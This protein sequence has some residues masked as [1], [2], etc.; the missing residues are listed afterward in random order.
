LP[1]KL[2]I[3]KDICLG[4]A[5]LHGYKIIHRDLKPANILLDEHWNAKICDF[6]LSEIKKNTI[7]KNEQRV[8]RGSYYW[9]SPEA[10]M[11]RP[12]DEKTDIYAIGIIIWQLMTVNN[13]PLPQYN[14]SSDLTEGVT[15]GVRPIFEK[16]TNSKINKKFDG[17]MLGYRKRKKTFSPR[18]HE[19]F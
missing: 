2:K 12:V 11:A 10:L 18:V 4:T 13:I 1:I 17:K 14:S 5:W 19:N 6:G 7:G 8:I 15:E 9:M 16:K 3:I